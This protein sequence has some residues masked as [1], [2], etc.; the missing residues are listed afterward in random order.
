MGIVSDSTSASNGPLASP[1]LKFRLLDS[2]P[3]DTM[4]T[5]KTKIACPVNNKF[6][7]ETPLNPSSSRSHCTSAFPLAVNID[8]F[9]H[10]FRPNTSVYNDNPVCKTQ[11]PLKTNPEDNKNSAKKAEGLTDKYKQQPAQRSVSAPNRSYTE[12][13]I[14]VIPFPI[15]EY[16]TRN[17][18]PAIKNTKPSLISKGSVCSRKMTRMIN[19]QKRKSVSDC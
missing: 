13:E 14:P 5:T 10:P 6:I 4:L 15:T 9:R 19:T 11:V 12:P 2:N 1:H 16:S 18:I 3:N 7:K 8:I 17:E